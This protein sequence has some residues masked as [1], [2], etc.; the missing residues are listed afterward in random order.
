M[1]PGGDTTGARV[2]ATRRSTVDAPGAVVPTTRSAKGRLAQAASRSAHKRASA[3]P[4]LFRPPTDLRATLRP[5]KLKRKLKAP[6]TLP[7]L[8]LTMEFDEPHPGV[9]RRFE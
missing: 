9:R 6:D 7:L 1:T 2:V 3:N 4:G 8:F 5:N